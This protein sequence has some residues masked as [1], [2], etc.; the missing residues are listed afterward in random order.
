MSEPTLNEIWFSPR[1]SMILAQL[2][3]QAPEGRIVEIGS[4]EGRSTIVIANA[5]WPRPVEAVDH[6]LGDVSDV[7]LELA[8]QRDVHATWLHNMDVAG[9]DNV[10]EHNMDWRAHRDSDDRPVALVFIDAAHTYEQVDA[11]IT[12]YMKIMAPGGIVCGDDLPINDV[13]RAVIEHFGTIE[14]CERLWWKRL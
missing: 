2:V 10:I 13:H 14:T 3:E 6:W 4:W 7:T 8:Q 5:A 12:A 1:D 11:Q 9:C